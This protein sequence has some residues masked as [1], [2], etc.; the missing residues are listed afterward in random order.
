[1]TAFSRNNLTLGG[2]PSSLRRIFDH[3]DQRGLDDISRRW[4]DVR[5]YAPYHASRLFSLAHAAQL[6][7]RRVGRSASGFNK[8]PWQL[9]PRILIGSAT[10]MPYRPTSRRQLIETVVYNI[11]AQPIRWE[12]V[13]A[14]CKM[15]L[16]NF[17]ASKW[18]VRTF[19]QS[20]LAR[21]FSV[22]LQS[23]ADIHISLDEVFGVQR[24]QP[25]RARQFPIAV[26]GMAGRFP[27][28]DNI[29]AFWDILKSGTDCHEPVHHLVQ[30]ARSNRD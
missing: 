27:K 10:G 16:D 3:F 14:G 17:D 8:D 19:G 24:S 15:T 11:L 22:A 29:E 6:V 28:A 7:E 21:K 2:P 9:Q 1:M 4:R 30:P 25:P 26:V 12:D 20:L 5:I 23:A 13:I 18:A